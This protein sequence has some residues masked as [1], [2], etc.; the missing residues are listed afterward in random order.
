MPQVNIYSGEGFGEVAESMFGWMTR[1]RAQAGAPF[2]A[3]T[4]RTRSDMRG[5]G[6][7]ALPVVF[8]R[9]HD[10]SWTATWLHLYLTGSPNSNRVEAN[11]AGTALLVR[12]MLRRRYLTVAHLVGLMR[13]AGTEVAEW[14]PGTEL[15]GPVTFLGVHQPDG[16]PAGS[17]VITLDRLKR[18]VPN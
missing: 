18:L 10:G 11:Q 5:G 15:G 8:A 12:G 9:C 4:V 14:E 16:L 13:A 7:V 1:D 2:E 6:R 17:E 3:R